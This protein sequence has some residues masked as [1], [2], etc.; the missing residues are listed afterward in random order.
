[1]NFKKQNDELSNKNDESSSTAVPSAIQP[2]PVFK[3][4]DPNIMDHGAAG[5]QNYDT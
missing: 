1:M 4:R 2:E 3:H 5:L